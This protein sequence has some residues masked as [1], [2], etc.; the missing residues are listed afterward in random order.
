MA[1]SVSSDFKWAMQGNQR[2]SSVTQFRITDFTLKDANG[3]CVSML[4]RDMKVDSQSEFSLEGNLISSVDSSVKIHHV[5]LVKRYVFDLGCN[6][7]NS[8]YSSEGIWMFGDDSNVQYQLIYPA[9]EEYKKIADIPELRDYKSVLKFYVNHFHDRPERALDLINIKITD[10]RTGTVRPISALLSAEQSDSGSIIAG[11]GKDQTSHNRN[12]DNQWLLLTGKIKLNVHA[13]CVTQWD[14]SKIML[15]R[16]INV[17]TII[18]PKIVVDFG[19]DENIKFDP[20]FW[21]NN[22][23]NT[24]I[25][26]NPN[27]QPHPEYP[28]SFQ[29]NATDMLPFN[30]ARNEDQEWRC[31]TNFRLMGLL[32]NPHHLEITPLN[33]VFILCGELK[34][35]PQSIRRNIQVKVHVKMHA[36][37]L[38]RESND[39][40]RGAWLID[41]HG[42]LYKLDTP[43]P[44]YQQLADMLLV[45]TEKLLRFYD[46]MRF[47]T[48]SEQITAYNEVTEK[49]SCNW[50]LQRIYHQAKLAFDLKFVQDNVTF[51]LEALSPILDLTKS[52]VFIGSMCGKLRRILNCL[53]L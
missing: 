28:N 22:C 51:V 30:W 9:A 38:G 40:E 24:L 19:N 42:T 45:K 1:T 18:Q 13:H 47:Q 8:S 35:T 26:L 36:I 41:I 49:Y 12:E 29:L 48:N 15:L 50:T 10:T 25:K 17:Q 37:D 39:P 3:N 4:L 32:G 6:F 20:V 23:H 31:V 11:N 27:T 14:T 34:S 21:V 43:H 46:V 52:P 33:T 7:R 2:I 5:A 53:D 16:F 44:E